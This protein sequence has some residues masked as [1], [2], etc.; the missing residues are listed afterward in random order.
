MVVSPSLLNR[1]DPDKPV[2]L[3]LRLGMEEL[4]GVSVNP[5]DY[6]SQHDL[7][8]NEVDTLLLAASQSYESGATANMDYQIDDLLLA[9]STSKQFESHCLPSTDTSYD[10]QCG[11][12]NRFE[13]PQSAGKV[14]AVKKSRIPKKTQANTVWA[15]NIWRKWAT[16]C[17]KCLSQEERSC[18]HK[19]NV[20]IRYCCSLPWTVTTILMYAE[21]F[22]VCSFFCV[23]IITTRCLTRPVS[24][25]L[26]ITSKRLLSKKERKKV[27]KSEDRQFACFGDL[28]VW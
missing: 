22:L 2:P 4:L 19:L 21:Y 14:E 25:L 6:L 8:D 5:T 15:E 3:D 1:I 20:E 10:A 18:G 17:L 24:L 27:R 7:L 23:L 12:L 28:P 16:Y 9:V 26:L 11:P 13:S